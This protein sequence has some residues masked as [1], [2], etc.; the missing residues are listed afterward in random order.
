MIRTRMKKP[1]AGQDSGLG[2]RRASGMQLPGETIAYRSAPYAR[3]I[4]ERMRAGKHPNVY[5]FAGSDGW[6]LAEH[7]RRTHGE[8]TALVLPPGDD[9]EQFR[10]PALDA[11]VAIP[12]DCSGDRFRRLVVALLTAGCRCIIEIRPDQAPTA[13]YADE[14][15]AP[16]VAA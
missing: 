14:R 11:L 8:G 2:G 4:L 13:H 7:R 16:E 9:P 12:G 5:A 10:W 1:A 15:D 3:A 6:N